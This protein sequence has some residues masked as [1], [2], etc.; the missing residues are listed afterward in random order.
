MKICPSS[1]IIRN[2]QN[3]TM[4]SYHLTS[5]EMALIQRQEKTSVEEDVVD[6]QAF[7]NSRMVLRHQF[8]LILCTLLSQEILK[9]LKLNLCPH[10]SQELFNTPTLLSC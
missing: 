8:N 3:K 7:C 9:L 4:V 10:V 1:L 2:M 6:S 5:M